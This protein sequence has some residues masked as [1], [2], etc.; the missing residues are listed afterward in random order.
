[1]KRTNKHSLQTKAAACFQCGVEGCLT[2]VSIAAVKHHDQKV[3]C[4]R[5][6]LFNLINFQLIVHHW[7]KSGEELKQGR[8]LEAGAD[9]EAMEGCHLL[10][11]SSWLALPAFL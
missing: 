9:A 10:A 4:G 8:S 11:Y 1:M 6:G 5:K 3:N 7:R 2:M